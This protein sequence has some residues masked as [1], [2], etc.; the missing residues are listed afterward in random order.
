MRRLPAS[1]NGEVFTASLSSMQHGL[2]CGGGRL[3]LIG[4]VGC[5]IAWL[6]VL[7]D[8]HFRF[9]AKKYFLI[10]KPKMP[11]QNSADPFCN[12]FTNVHNRKA[13]KEKKNDKFQKLFFP[14]LITAT[15]FF[16]GAV[17]PIWRRIPQPLTRVMDTHN[18]TT[19]NN[20]N[21]HI[22]TRASKTTTRTVTTTITTI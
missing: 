6:L 16:R 1:D 10:G 20:N 21:S 19:H 5:C 18:N 9:V 8:E 22:S 12:M 17:P 4:C 14:T 11:T 15:T 7:F 3:L 13:Q 2:I